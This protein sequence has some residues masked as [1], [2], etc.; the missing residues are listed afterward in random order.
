MK[1][2]LIWLRNSRCFLGL[3]LILM[4]LGV[5]K[6]SMDAPDYAISTAKKHNSD[7]ILL[8]VIPP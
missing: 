2:N 4:A 8:H 5:S 7:L 3:T 1:Y 6:S